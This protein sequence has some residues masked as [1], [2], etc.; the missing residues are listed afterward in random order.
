[1]ISGLT[2]IRRSRQLL[3]CGRV[4]RRGILKQFQNRRRDPLRF[5][6]PQEPLQDL[7]QLFE[8]PQPQ[9][10]TMTEMDEL[11]LPFPVVP[12]LQD[13]R[14]VADESA[15]RR[16][17]LA[18]LGALT[19]WHRH[20]AAV[21]AVG[22]DNPQLREVYQAIDRLTQSPNLV[23]RTEAEKTRQALNRA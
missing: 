7:N 23:V 17:V 20:A 14:E 10:Q 11:H 13:G 12:G 6:L 21:Q 9:T 3:L 2:L 1:M 16:T 22:A 8:D 15:A 18:A 4:N 5:R 19:E